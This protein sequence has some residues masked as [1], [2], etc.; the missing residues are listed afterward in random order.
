MNQI[1]NQIPH[2]KILLISPIFLGEDVWKQEYDPEFSPESV[3]VSKQ[4]GDVYERVAKKYN[5]SFLRASDYAWP[6]EADREHFTEAGHKALADA[7][8]RKLLSELLQTGQQ[9]G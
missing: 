1:R 4:L 6:S 5:I 3:K 2:A 9:A 8:T 7:V